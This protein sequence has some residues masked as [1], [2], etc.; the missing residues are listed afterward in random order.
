VLTD[1]GTALAVLL[2]RLHHQRAHS[3]R[4]QCR[5]HRRSHEGGALCRDGPD[6]FGAAVIELPARSEGGG[7]ECGESTFFVMQLS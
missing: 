2:D 5:S 6:G 4:G 3:R 1:L 7:E